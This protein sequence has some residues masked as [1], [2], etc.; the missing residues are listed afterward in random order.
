MEKAKKAMIKKEAIYARIV[1][2]EDGE[3]IPVL[4][5]VRALK[6]RIMIKMTIGITEL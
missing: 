2:S 3:K 1:T 5:N 4:R 6:V